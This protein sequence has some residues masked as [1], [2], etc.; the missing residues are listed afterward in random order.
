MLKYFLVA[1]V[2]TRQPWPRGTVADAFCNRLSGGASWPKGL[3]RSFWLSRLREF[4]L[5]GSRA[6]PRPSTGN[7]PAGWPSR[8]TT[9]L[10]RQNSVPG[11]NSKGKR[12]F[13][14][15]LW[16]S[17]GS[18]IQKTEGITSGTS[19][20]LTCQCSQNWQSAG[21]KARKSR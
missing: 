3:P 10:R 20:A 6:S 19:S 4:R 11:V 12:G 13:L 2:L 9:P 7:S 8:L 21:T 15:P 16:K 1:E 18:F 17:F 14:S 5:S